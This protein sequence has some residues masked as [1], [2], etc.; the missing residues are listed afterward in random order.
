MDCIYCRKDST[1]SKSAEHVIPA[2]LGCKDTLPLG[3]VC[4]GCNNYFSQ[5]DKIVLLHNYI[6]ITT[7]AEQIPNRDGKLREQ[8][9][10]RFR[11]SKAQK[12]HAQIILGP[13]EIGPD[14]KE[15][16]FTM[17]QPGEFKEVSFARG[18]HKIAFNSFALRFG[19]TESH[20]DC[21]NKVRQYVRAA[22]KNDFWQY[23]VIPLSFNGSYKADFYNYRQGRVVDFN[24][25]GLLFRVSLEGWHTE[26]ESWHE[27]SSIVRGPNH[28]SEPSLLGLRHNS[29]A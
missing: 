4:D 28:W 10:P 27:G 26:F 19:Y 2:S 20:R 22:S 12:G 25:P 16:T 23:M 18:I 24:L 11:F 7:G 17:Q 13:V 15:A 21:F 14:L 1:S 5:I 8:I 29:T 3:F 9:G 6:A